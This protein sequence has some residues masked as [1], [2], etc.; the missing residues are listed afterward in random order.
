MTELTHFALSKRAES[1]PVRRG[2][3]NNGCF[4]SNSE[5]LGKRCWTKK[6]K[7]AVG[8]LTFIEP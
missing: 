3:Q 4:S 2:K 1:L 5:L 8:R 7:K 6:R